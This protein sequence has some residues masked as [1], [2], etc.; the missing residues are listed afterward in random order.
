MIS[1]NVG[2]SS[3]SLGTLSR[4]LRFAVHLLGH[5]DG[6]TAQRFAATTEKRFADKSTWKWHQDGLPELVP[7]SI[8]RLSGNIVSLSAAGDNLIAL[9]AVEKISRSEGHPLVYQQ[10]LY[11]HLD[12]EVTR[13]RSN[14]RMF[15]NAFDMSCVGHQ[16]P[17][18]WAHP[19]DRASTYKDIEYW[20]DMAQLLE[21][22]GFDSLFIADVV[23]IYD[24]Y[25]GSRDPALRSSAQVPVNDPVG[26]ISAMAAVTKR[27]GF[28]VT[29]S[30]SYELPYAF[31]RRMSTLDHLTKGR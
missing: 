18:L 25:Q 26:P 19:T 12:L 2:R 22:G 31:A 24:I 15:L 9:G 27:L 11:R 6:H 7:G 17:G 1:F 4:S 23:G 20:T 14:R 5:E 29:V 30:L 3:S 28:G 13:P 8:A 10:G 16:A 21:R